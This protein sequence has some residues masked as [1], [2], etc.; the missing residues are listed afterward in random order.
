MRTCGFDF[1]K[2]DSTFLCNN[3]E[4]PGPVR[5]SKASLIGDAHFA[6][7]EERLGN[8]LFFPM[9]AKEKSHSKMS[10]AGVESGPTAACDCNHSTAA[11]ADDR[12]PV[13]L[14]QWSKGSRFMGTFVLRHQTLTREE[15]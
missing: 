1:R 14:P 9:L 4:L 11:Y 10:S 12:L 2:T 5:A 7:M 3:G 6:I 13:A 8:I 15:L